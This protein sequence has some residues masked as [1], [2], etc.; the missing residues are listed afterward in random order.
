M[1]LQKVK[2]LL[3]KG[4]IAGAVKE[5]L[6]W[7]EKSSGLEKGDVKTYLVELIKNEEV[8]SCLDEA[9]CSSISKL[10]RQ[11]VRN[12]DKYYFTGKAYFPVHAPG[13]TRLVLL[14]IENDSTDHIINFD[15][16]YESKGPFMNVIMHLWRYLN[17][18]ITAPGTSRSDTTVMNWGHKYSIHFNP[19]ANGSF[20]TDGITQITGESLHFAAVVAT[21]SAI[22][23]RYVDPDIVFTG[24]FKSPVESIPV[25]H[26]KEK[27]EFILKNRPLT[28]KIIIPSGF[29]SSEDKEYIS[30][31]EGL[32]V[33][34]NSFKE[35]IEAT[36][37]HSVGKVLE[38]DD[39]RRHSIGFCRLISRSLGTMEIPLFDR[40]GNVDFN[41]RRVTFN[42]VYFTMKDNGDKTRY[43][44]F[45]I[46]K[47]NYLPLGD[48]KYPVLIILDFRGTIA[49]TGNMI[50][51]NSQVKDIFAVGVGY[52]ATLAQIFAY[53]QP[54]D[55]ELVGKYFRLDQIHQKL[56][57]GV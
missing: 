31:H 36:F 2:E 8:L 16:D 22:T 46:T 14:K 30:N 6:E 57:T 28:K 15:L 21:V 10:L 27:V 19:F 18:T 34:V 33:Q 23:G 55:Q 42:V 40:V 37:G 49:H 20:K 1:S 12:C 4:A 32:F 41:D 56:K 38:L 3:K 51:N 54:T 9:T 35:L 39:S 44:V 52:D 53:P 7:H 24:C 11:E 5:C 17:Q 50:S 29:F 48:S 43:Q 13:D 25:T 26:L 47:F 45:P